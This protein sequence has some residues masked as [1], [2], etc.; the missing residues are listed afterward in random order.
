MKVSSETF[1]IV[2]ARLVYTD[3]NSEELTHVQLCHG[4]NVDIEA[5]SL[6]TSRPSLAVTV[7]HCPAPVSH[8]PALRMSVDWARVNT[9]APWILFLVIWL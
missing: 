7:Y 6:L 3:K 1:L 4:S 5:L 9:I 8:Q 2:L